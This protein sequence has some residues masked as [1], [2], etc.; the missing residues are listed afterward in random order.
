MMDA[1]GR[2]ASV[3]PRRLRRGTVFGLLL[4]VFVVRLAFGVTNDFFGED[5]FQVYLIGLKFFTTG[6]WPLY[7]ADVVYTETHVPGGLQGLLVGGP[8]YLLAQPEAPY[9]LLNALSLAA[10]SLLGWYITRRVPDVPRWF[11]WPWIFFMPWTFDLSAHIINT[12]YVLCGA[13]PFFVGAFELVPALRTGALSRRLSFFFLGL[14]LFWVYQIHMSAA[15]LAPMALVVLVLVAWHDRAAALRGIPW[16]LLGALVTIP[17]LI[18][19]LVAVGPAAVAGSTRANIVFEP[20]HLLRLPQVV[21]QFFSFGSFELPRFIGS[22][23]HDRLTFLV[24]YWWAAPFVVLATLIG[25]LQTGV[26]LVGLFRSP[27]QRADWPAVRA[28]TAIVVALVFASFALSVKAPASHAFYAVFPVVTIYAFYWWTSLFSIRLVRM[29]AVSLLVAG[30]ITHLA[31]A[32]RNIADRSL[33]T[34]R[35][36]V[37]RAIQERNHH[38]LGELRRDRWHPASD[39]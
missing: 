6:V 29:L 37:M 34:N 30:G 1:T 39:E 5:E 12:S 15:L 9:V 38:L 22:N 2:P 16:F 11:L 10:L 36:L 35:A 25:M 21:L 31:I 23:T 4:L 27:A 19:T 33:Y 7:G 13:V 28:T 8:L 14:G 32:S 26:L 20:D 18:P 3:V 17:S 24:R